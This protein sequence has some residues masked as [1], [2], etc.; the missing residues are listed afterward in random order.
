M[1]RWLLLILLL[2]GCINLPVEEVKVTVLNDDGCPLCD[3]SKLEGDLIKILNASFNH[4]DVSSEEGK[5][6]IE[7]Y[8]VVKVPFV[9]VEGDLNE[10]FNQI[11]GLDGGMEKMGDVYK[12][13]DEITGARWYIDEVE[14][15]K[16]YSLLG[17]EDFQVDVFVLDGCAY[18]GQ[19]VDALEEASSVLGVESNV[20]DVESELGKELGVEYSPMIFMNGLEYLGPRSPENF[21]DAMCEFLS[22]NMGCLVD[23][24]NTD[25]YPVQN[26][27][28]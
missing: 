19:A 20:H 6:L 8:G 24:N 28:I 4:V 25:P 23:L 14:K 17:I 18:A 15:E 16:Y 11:P 22:G 12:I 27:L 10:K 7:E 13:K 1:K 26:C 9:I 3:T 5:S 21:K 2:T